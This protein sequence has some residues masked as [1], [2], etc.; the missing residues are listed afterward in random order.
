M[1]SYRLKLEKLKQTKKLLEY[2]LEDQHYNFKKLKLKNDSVSNEIET[3][4]NEIFKLEHKD[5]N[6][7]KELY[8]KLL[9]DYFEHK[10]FMYGG[11]KYILEK[12]VPGSCD[13]YPR[14]SRVDVFTGYCDCCSY[15]NYYNV[16]ICQDMIKQAIKNSYE[17]DNSG[18]NYDLKYIFC[19]D[20][21]LCININNIELI[22]DSHSDIHEDMNSSIMNYPKRIEYKKE[23]IFYFIPS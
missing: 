18:P 12:Y 11:T 17:K 8:T 21:G 9:K 14:C 13:I 10:T 7:T 15:R 22:F 5:D 1:E 4:E 3:V 19:G 16:P 2:Q 23:A 6:E 20:R